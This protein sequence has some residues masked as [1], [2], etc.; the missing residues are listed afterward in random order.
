MGFSVIQTSAEVKR[1]F[2]ANPFVQKIP[3]AETAGIMHIDRKEQRMSDGR[4]TLPAPLKA[5]GTGNSPDK[6][7]F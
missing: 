1:L 3:F 4:R 6:E 2:Y 5:A 7:F